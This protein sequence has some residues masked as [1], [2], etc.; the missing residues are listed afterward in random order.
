L[1]ETATTGK[2]VDFL[3]KYDVGTKSY[4]YSRDNLTIPDESTKAFGDLT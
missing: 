1:V 2:T 3:I 4:S